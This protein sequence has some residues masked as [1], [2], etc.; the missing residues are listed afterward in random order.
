MFEDEG[1][2][3]FIEATPASESEQQ[4]DTTEQVDGNVED[5]QATEQGDIQDSNQVEKTVPVDVV[6][7]IRQ[8]MK[9]VKEERDRILN[10]VL[11]GKHL[12][13]Q[14]VQPVAE[15]DPFAGIDRD[16]F[17]TV[18]G[19]MDLWEKKQAQINAR[20]AQEAHQ[21]KV[22]KLGETEAS[23]RQT[24]PDYDEVVKVLPKDIQ[25]SLFKT[26]PDTTELVNVAYKIGKALKG[27]SVPSTASTVAAKVDVENKINQNLNKPK[28]LSQ[29]KGASTNSDDL[30][31]YVD[32]IWAKL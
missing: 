26:Y 16:D 20:A 18:G 30:D 22:T 19:A 12:P 24:N 23:F 5:T 13:Q 7:S 8:E 25:I 9:A 29:A 14:Q 3:E 2:G 28:T 27:E 31:K 32:E 17:I 10:L 4:I 6:E 15:P 11:E 1:M 21:V